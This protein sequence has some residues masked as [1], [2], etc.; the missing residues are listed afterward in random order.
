MPVTIHAG[1]L[2][3]SIGIRFL[4]ISPVIAYEQVFYRN[5]APEF[6]ASNEN[7]VNRLQFHFVIRRCIDKTYRRSW[8][9]ELNLGN[10]LIEWRHVRF[11]AREIVISFLEAI[12]KLLVFARFRLF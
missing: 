12:A 5:A 8:E 2:Q 1:M 11:S 10:D 4:G 9:I 7:V 6:I 3:N